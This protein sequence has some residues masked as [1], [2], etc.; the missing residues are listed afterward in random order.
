MCVALGKRVADATGI[1]AG[2]FAHACAL[3]V[4]QVQD[5]RTC[6]GT[7]GVAAG[8]V[9]TTGRGQQTFIHI[10]TNKAI[11]L[12]SILALADVGSVCVEAQ[13]L[14]ATVVWQGGVLIAF[15]HIL[16]VKAVALHARCTGT[17]ERSRRVNAARNWM[18]SSILDL[19]LIK[20]YNLSKM[21]Q[22]QGNSPKWC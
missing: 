11:A 22:C 17:V 9:P 12:V 3:I 6:V 4:R 1:Q 14:R 16:A 19:A 21:G 15:V 13:S 20:V 2:A 7:R 18:A 8:H 5:T 10:L